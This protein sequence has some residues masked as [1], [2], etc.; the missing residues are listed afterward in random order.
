MQ[1]LELREKLQ[2][3]NLDNISMSRKF[4]ITRFGLNKFLKNY[5]NFIYDKEIGQIKKVIME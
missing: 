5:T 4:Y 2:V 1:I 3:S